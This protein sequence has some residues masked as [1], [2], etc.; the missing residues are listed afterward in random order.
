MRRV[1]NL[2]ITVSADDTAG[3]TRG[4]ANGLGEAIGELAAGDVGQGFEFEYDLAGDL[5]EYVLT[6]ECID[7]DAL[8][9]QVSAGRAG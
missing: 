1:L 5:Y 8:V 3:A 7:P 9:A 6:G 2:S 4:I